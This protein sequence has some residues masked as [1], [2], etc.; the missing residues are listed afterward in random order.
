[1]EK[2][3]SISKKIK[4]IKI[5]NPDNSRNVK[6]YN[7]LNPE[8]KEINYLKESFNFEERHLRASLSKISSQRPMIY[9]EGKYLFLILHFPVVEKG[10]IVSGEIEFFVGHGYL[11]TLHDG[12]TKALNDFFSYCEKDAIFLESYKL[13]SS[14]ILLYELLE[15]L[16][17]DSYE[18]LDENNI[19]ISR[20]EKKI[21]S[22]E[23]KK[24]TSELLKLKSNIISI[25]RTVQNHKNIMKKLTGMKSSLVPRDQIIKHYESLADHSQR[26]WEFS[27]IQKEII[28]SLHETSESILSYR[29]ND[30][31]RTLTI[32]SVILMPLNL[33][34]NLFGMNL[35]PSPISSG[36]ISFINIIV[37]M[38]VM[39]A[40]MLLFFKNKKW[41]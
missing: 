31:M 11:I 5:N 37:I 7:I 25:R 40:A 35:N 34:V 2:I 41:L 10:R 23:Q 1:M 19:E 29:T 20:V 9:Q 30:I 13:E 16:I 12:K 32:V 28:E 17:Q 4:A 27:E 39:A 6:W 15:K 22:R 36:L 26:I 3:E 21:F 8:E 24:I 14:A 33:F 38:A 18:L